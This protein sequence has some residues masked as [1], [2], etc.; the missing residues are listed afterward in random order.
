MS[1]NK[2]KDIDMMRGMA[3]KGI[4][5]S[6]YRSRERRATWQNIADNLNSCEEFAVTAQSLRDDFTTLMRRYKSKKYENQRYRS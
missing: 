2:E 4:F 3:S 5:E 6:K 1:W